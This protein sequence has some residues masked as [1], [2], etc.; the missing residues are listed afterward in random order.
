MTAEDD[1]NPAV[2]AWLD[3]CRALAAQPLE[4]I[5]EAADELAAMAADRGVM[6]RARRRLLVEADRAPADPVLKQMLSLWRRAFERGQWSW[7]D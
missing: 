7:E 4:G 2:G 5:D 6:E 3:R 1:G